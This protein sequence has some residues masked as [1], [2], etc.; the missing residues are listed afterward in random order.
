MEAIILDPLYSIH[1][2]TIVTGII[3]IYIYIHI[4]IYIYIL[5]TRLLG[6]STPMV[7]I[8]GESKSIT[9]TNIQYINNMGSEVEGLIFH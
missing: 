9:L 6:Q 3:Y 7:A 2:A 8:V 5:D 1:Y 4:Y